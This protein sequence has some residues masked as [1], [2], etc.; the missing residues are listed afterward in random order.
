MPTILSRGFT[1]HEH[2]DDFALIN[3]NGRVYDP[4]LGMFLSPDNYVQAPTHSQSFS[5]TSGSD[6]DYV[7]NEELE[8]ASLCPSC[9]PIDEVVVTW[10][11]GWYYVTGRW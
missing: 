1:G 2:L 11:K 5:Y 3:M 4:I 7:T 9:Y 10:E 8:A 6:G